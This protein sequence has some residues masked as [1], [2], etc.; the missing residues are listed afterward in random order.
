MGVLVHGDVGDVGPGGRDFTGDTA[1]CS[2]L[3]FGINLDS[4]SIATE[5]VGGPGDFDPAFR[6]FFTLALHRGA[7]VSVN[8]ESM[9]SAHVTDDP[10][11]GEW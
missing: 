11:A 7:F 3:I 5:L 6:I 8:R 9:A 4:G 1:Q 2:G 10:V